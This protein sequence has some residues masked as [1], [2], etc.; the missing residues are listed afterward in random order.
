MSTYELKVLFGYD[1]VRRI[2]SINQKHNP[3]ILNASCFGSRQI[4]EFEVRERLKNFSLLC[5]VGLPIMY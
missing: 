5:G 3:N 1:D 4:D 2:N